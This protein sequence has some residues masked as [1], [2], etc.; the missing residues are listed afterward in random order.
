MITTCILIESNLAT[1]QGNV[2][3]NIAQRE[4]DSERYR[5][6]RIVRLLL[7][8][9]ADSQATIDNKLGSS[10]IAGFIAG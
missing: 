7:V 8:R 1:A 10:R 4:G 3:T 5:S 9:D 2:L 6:I